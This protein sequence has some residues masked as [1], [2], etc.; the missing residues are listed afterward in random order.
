[1]STPSGESDAPRTEA[2]SPGADAH[3]PHERSSRSF[4]KRHRR[5]LLAMLG[6]AAVVGFFYYV[7]PQIAGLGST[8]HRLRAADK[9]WLGLGVVVEA[10]SIGCEIVLLHGIFARRGGRIGWRASYDIELAGGAATKVFAAAGSGGVA[11]TVW[12][13]RAAGRKP[14][15]VAD[16]MVCFEL[17]EYGVYMAALVIAGFGLWLGVFS[18]PA[19]VGLTLIPAVFGLCVILIVLSARVADS[20]FERFL[21]RRAAHSQGRA[22]QRWSR[23]ATLPRVLRGGLDAAFAMLRRRDPSLL[24]ALGVWGFDIAALWASFR[25]F[26]HAPPGAVLVMGYYVGTLANMLPIPGGI[27]AVEGGMI[28]SFLAFGVNGSLAVLAVL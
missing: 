22:K 3:P 21:A 16:G 7:V 17:L 14:E 12:A 24:G 1:M 11:L 2:R 20:P 5:V 6:A 19:P 13:L 23:A 15:E 4:F 10:L 8:L 25:A 9:W 26:G 28:G 18:G 27:G